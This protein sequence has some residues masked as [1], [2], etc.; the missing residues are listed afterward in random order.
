MDNPVAE[1]LDLNGDGLPDVLVTE[2][3]G[4][5]HTA[6]LNR[7]PVSSGGGQV[8]NWQAA[9]QMDSVDGRALLFD[10]QSTAPIA[11]LA[12]IVV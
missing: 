4:G 10:L 11:H 7:G 2:A 8:I 6:Y 12:D 3:G 9:V 5:T 1:F